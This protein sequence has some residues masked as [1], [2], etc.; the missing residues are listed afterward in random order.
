MSKV[1]CVEGGA[2]GADKLDALRDGEMGGFACGAGDDGDG[3]CFGDVE[4]V[5][6]E[7]GDVEVFCVG[8]EE[9]R[10]GGVDSPREG[11]GV[12]LSPNR[13]IAE[14]PWTPPSPL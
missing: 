1:G 5:G 10:E 14:P 9:G 8:E 7:R 4:D 12:L 13:R 6:R 11:G 2:G 3:A